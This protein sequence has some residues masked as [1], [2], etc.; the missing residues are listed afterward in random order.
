MLWKGEPGD[1]FGR[2]KIFQIFIYSLLLLGS[3]FLCSYWLGRQGRYFRV[4]QSLV[5]PVSVFLLP[6]GPH[7][8]WPHTV[9]LKWQSDL[10][11]CS[12]S[13]TWRDRDS[14]CRYQ[15]GVQRTFAAEVGA[16]QSRSTFHSASQLSV[17]IDQG[18][19][20]ILRGWPPSLPSPGQFSLYVQNGADA[21][22]P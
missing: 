1:I 5:V 16:A 10:P 22:T 14:S 4:I 15:P 19:E 21:H 12:Y 9:A 8:G 18:W 2:K 20:S 7:P 6:F 13:E 11:D 3:R 17:L